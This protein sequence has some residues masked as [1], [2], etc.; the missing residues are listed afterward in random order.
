MNVSTGACTI[1]IIMQHIPH[2]CN[3]KITAKLAKSLHSIRARELPSMHS[4]ADELG[5]DAANLR[6][7]QSL[8]QYCLN[9]RDT[10]PLKVVGV[11]M[12]PRF[13]HGAQPSI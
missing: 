4:T 7:M 6:S 9:D 8:Q 13:T 12:A 11:L 2:H 1:V 10:V 5:S 3:V